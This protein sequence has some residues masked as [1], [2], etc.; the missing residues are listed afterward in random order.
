MD[1]SL[2]PATFRT[3][4]GC[5]APIIPDTWALDWAGGTEAES[6]PVT[7]RFGIPP[8]RLDALIQW[9]SHR[10]D[11]DF[12]WPNVFLTR[13]AAQEFCATFI[14]SGGDAFILGLALSSTD[15]DDFLSQTAP[16]PG[17][18]AIGLHQL[19]ARRLLPSEGGV[20]LGS[21]VLGVEHGGSLHSSLCNGLERAFAQH[22]GARPNRYGLFDDHALAQ[23]CA[24][25]AGSEAS[26][27]EPIPW[28][29]WVLTEYPRAVGR[30]P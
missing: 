19:L 1:A 27:A 30:P 23:R 28:Q 18:T 4:S 26:Q 7:A 24:A 22:L 10:F 15:A 14:P 21:E 3:A 2:I 16:L 20:P 5:L 12:L 29:A 13:E 6:L 8:D 9:V 11:T 17:Q 25:Y